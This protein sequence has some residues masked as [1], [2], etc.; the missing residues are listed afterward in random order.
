MFGDSTSWGAYDM[1]KGGWVNRLR[2]HCWEE[3]IDN[4]IY[5]L[6]ISGGTTE[7]ILERFER[8]ARSRKA[9]ALI[10]QSGG[11]DATYVDGKPDN[12]MVAAEKFEKNIREIIA[13]AKTIT[14]KMVFL[15]LKNCD[16]SKTLPVYWGPYYISNANL[17][18]YTNIM[19]SVCESEGVDCL[20]LENLENDEFE[21]GLH[22]NAA[23]HEKIYQQVRKFLE[24]KQWI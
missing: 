13:K 20:D 22:P 17:R 3:D 11:N 8:E 2:L 4:E 12:Y 16:E 6:S 14:D 23:G 18:K 7:A 10:F 9:Q 15:D 5:N 21:D 24:D 1:E 19:R